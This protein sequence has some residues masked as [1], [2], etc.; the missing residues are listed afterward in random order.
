M[1]ICKDNYLSIEKNNTL[2]N[3]KY[4]LTTI[5]VKIFLMLLCKL[6]VA[7]EGR[8]V[9]CI[10]RSELRKILKSSRD[11]TI[12]S[13]KGVLSEL[14][15]KPIYFLEK[16][17][18]E[19]EW[20]EYGFIGGYTYS[21][22][23]DEFQIEASQKIYDIV[24]NWS[25]DRYTPENLALLFGIRS[26]YTFRL[27]DLITQC[28]QKNVVSYKVQYIR[29]LLMLGEK[30]P[31]YADFKKRV[32][33]PAVKELNQAGIVNIQLV[34]KKNNKKVEVLEFYLDRS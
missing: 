17:E 24:K 9:C 21:K 25:K 30:Y 3:V 31:A 19:Y 4:N 27:Y 16:R 6:Q 5:E 20:G 12:E 34:E 18:E 32:I 22:N 28:D 10:S 15:K 14:R 13:I 8:L 2:V 26:A 33:V 1:V 7:D 29:E 23:S 11:C